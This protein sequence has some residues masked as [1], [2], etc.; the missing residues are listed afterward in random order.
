M[1]LM[2]LGLL[3]PLALLSCT[4]APDPR[5]IGLPEEMVEAHRLTGSTTVP[6]TASLVSYGGDVRLRITIDTSGKVTDVQID[7][8]GLNFG[9]P[10]PA[11]AVARQW[12]FRPFTYRGRPV[13]VTTSIDVNYLAK[14]VWADPK[15][16]FPV[17]DYAALRIELIRS[18]CGGFCPAYKVSIAGDG[19]VTYSTVASPRIAG[20]RDFVELGG[21]TVPG[22]HRSRI[23]R[24]ALDGLIGKFRAARFFGLKKE[25]DGQLSDS[26]AYTLAFSSGGRFWQVTD[27]VG[28]MV[29]MPEVVTALEDEVDRVA[30]TVRW[31]QGDETSLPAL[32]AEGF[33][34]RSPAAADFAR[35]AIERRGDA[36]VLDLLAAGLPLDRPAPRRVDDQA[37]PL[38]LVLLEAALRGG[39]PRVA[40][41]LIN[42]GWLGKMPP[43]DRARLFAESAGGCDPVVARAFVAAGVDPNA[44]ATDGG[45]ALHAARAL[46]PACGGLH[47]RVPLVGALLDLGVD[48][49]L[50]NA[51]GQT[52]IFDIQEPAVLDLLLAR[53]ARV[54]VQDK[55]GVSPVF[56]CWPDIIVRML[57]DA[58]AEPRGRYNGKTLATIARE[59]HM[60]ATSAWLAAHGID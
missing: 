5:I 13:G 1:N 31:V 60:P 11:L 2:R 34:P 40:R 22:T 58:G 45:T 29:G 16:A 26:A 54:R 50:G 47:D 55:R 38:G 17:I 3:V 27:Y 41:A 4:R 8:S 33:D 19:M 10:A 43:A 18:G 42:R 48:P 46:Y 24:A 23:D 56:A 7:K 49:N 57:L 25:Y 6:T 35:V 53:G 39:R 44:R 12:K 37:R 51:E 52:P 15:A 32:R 30:G 28:Q 20:L 59:Q 9:D 21:V 36:F 14:P